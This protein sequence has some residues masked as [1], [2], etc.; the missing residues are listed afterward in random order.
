MR[1]CI[2]VHM[3]VHALCLRVYE[4]TFVYVCGGQRIV[5]A[6]NPQM[7]STLFLE[8]VSLI[9][10]DTKQARLAPLRAPEICLSLLPLLLVTS[11]CY[12]ASAKSV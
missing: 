7:P 5:L 9:G 1:V 6:L 12:H 2:C 4:H 8:I 11:A 10:L 3:W